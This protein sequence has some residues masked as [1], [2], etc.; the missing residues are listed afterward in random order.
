VE[1]SLVALAGPGTNLLLFEVAQA[2]LSLGSRHLPPGL[3]AAASSVAAVNLG[4]AII[5]LVPIH[6]LDGSQAWRLPARW[7]R[8]RAE[9]RVRSATATRRDHLDATRR[10]YH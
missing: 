6:P 10:E 7:W 1:R 3:H 2:T 9:R 8:A 4:L 5:N